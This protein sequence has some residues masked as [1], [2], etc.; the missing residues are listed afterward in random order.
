VRAL[1]LFACAGVVAA[2]ACDLGSSEV[3]PRAASAGAETRAATAP[4]KG[5]SIFGFRVPAPSGA[6]LPETVMYV[7]TDSNALERVRTDRLP[8][9]IRSRE[10]ETGASEM[11][12]DPPVTVGTGT[13]RRLPDGST[14]GMVMTAKADWPPPIWVVNG[15]R[16]TAA[17]GNPLKNLSP[18]RIA[19]VSVWKGPQ[20][21]GRYGA[22][23]GQAVIEITTK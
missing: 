15:R 16:V 23:P 22:A 6:V 3:S 2:I 12:S 8:Y 11:T 4:P 10:H 19:S 21:V 1:G 7:R 5:D 9:K 18:D 17:E 13:A 20:A 14:T